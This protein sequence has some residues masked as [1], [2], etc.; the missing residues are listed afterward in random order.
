MIRR[1]PRSPLFP[2]TTLF[3]SVGPAQLMP[4]RAP[5]DEPPPAHG[6]A[7]EITYVTLDDQLAPGHGR[8]GVHPRVARDDQPA[9]GHARP[10][11]LDASQVALHPQL[12]VAVAGHGD[13]VAEPRP[14]V[15]VP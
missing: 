8:A 14:P 15:P 12:A 5:H 9:A 7:R 1:P 11:E 10:E 4:G 13:E 3:R 6:R 2:Y